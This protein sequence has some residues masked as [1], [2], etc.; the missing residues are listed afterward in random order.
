MRIAPSNRVASNGPPQPPYDAFRQRAATSYA[1][2]IKQF[3]AEEDRT[4]GP[5]RFAFGHPFSGRFLSE[6]PAGAVFE[7]MVRRS[8]P[9]FPGKDIPVKPWHAA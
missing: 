2:I 6:E 4:I 5:D 1:L 9:L 3:V 7:M 8:A